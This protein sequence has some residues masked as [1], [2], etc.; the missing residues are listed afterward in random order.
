MPC[1]LMSP[2]ITDDSLAL[3]AAAEAA[4]WQ[5]ERITS[6]PP[7]DRLA[8]ETDLVISA[9]AAFGGMLAAHLGC[10]LVSP[11][12]DWLIRLPPDYLRRSIEYQT[13]AEVRR[14]RGPLFVKTAVGL[15]KILHAAV[16]HDPAQIAAGLELP[17]EMLVLV[18]E[19]VRWVTEFR[20]FVMG[21]EVTTHSLSYRWG[22]MNGY[23]NRQRPVSTG[24]TL[25]AQAFAQRL[26]VD[27]RIALPRAFVLDI[28]YIAGRGW[29]VVEPNPAWASA[30]FGCEPAAV[31]PVLREACFR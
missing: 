15:F 3:Q 26:L 30:I 31:L 1:L 6:W 24:E 10:K 4:G 22:E 27:E 18:S 7:S 25:D 14:R 21:R 5:A 9:P 23:G 11:P 13:L 20:C 12:D 28:G 8:L 19:P 2:T 17:D 29:A 16:Y